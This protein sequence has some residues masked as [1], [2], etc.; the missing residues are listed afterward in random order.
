[1]AKAD[2]SLRK[3]ALRLIKFAAWRWTADAV[4]SSTSEVTID[5]IKTCP[6]HL[7]HT[8]EALA[9]LKRGEKVRHEHIVPLRK[10]VE[11]ALELGLKRSAGEVKKLFEEYCKAALVTR[12]QDHDL[13]DNKLRDQMPAGW[14]WGDDALD[15]YRQCGLQLCKPRNS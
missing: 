4:D 15:R 14:Q 13:N 10:L 12:E 1:M 2:P 11:R 8:K 9:A 7:P 3:V 6:A 5:A